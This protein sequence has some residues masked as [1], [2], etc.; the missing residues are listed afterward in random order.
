MIAAIAVFTPG[1]ILLA[2][3]FLLIGRYRGGGAGPA[4][5]RPGQATPG[6]CQDPE[7][8]RTQISQDGSFLLS[9]KAAS[10]ISACPPP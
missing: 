7:A 5:G 4:R 8:A 3:S 2:S 10:S 1:V 6:T 9:V